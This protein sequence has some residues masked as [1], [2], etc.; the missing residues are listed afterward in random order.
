MDMRLLGRSGLRVPAFG[1]GAMT[2]GGE[3]RFARIGV[4]ALDEARRMV[5]MCLDA[6]ATLFDTADVYSFGRSEEIL[7]QALGSRRQEAIVA[8]KAFMRMGAGENDLG[9]SRRHLVAACEASLKRLGT[10]WIDLYQLHHYDALTP[11]DET[12]RA[13]DDLVRA[14][15][16][17]YVGCSNYSGWQLMKAL[18]V[19]DRSGASRFVSQQIYYSLLA[20]EAENELVPLGLEEGVGILVWSGLAW[21]L[22]SGKFGRGMPPPA[23]ARASAGGPNQPASDLLFAILDVAGE[24]A[25][26]RGATVAQVALNWLADKPGVSSVLIGA[27]DEAQ[28]KE[29]LAAATWRLTVGETARL[30]AVSRP[31][32]AYPYWVQK[33]YAGER[34]PY[35][36]NLDR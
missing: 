29:N 28:L 3:G 27:R 2:F 20:R 13:L 8:T 36:H 18:A 15:K 33:V 16:V 25:R 35:T 24:I 19:A 31:V 32:R 14:G 10:D 23:V 9:T 7:G 21:G 5:G 12:V 4:T 26:D 34:N 6:G 17:R 30:D 11:V 22:L 1:F